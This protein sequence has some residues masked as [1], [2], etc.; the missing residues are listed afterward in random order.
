MPEGPDLLELLGLPPGGE[1]ARAGPYVRVPSPRR[2][3]SVRPRRVIALGLLA[4][5]LGVGAWQLSL[6]PSNER[7]WAPEQAVLPHV[8]IRGDTARVDRLRDFT[9][10]SDTTAVERYD[11]RTYDL[12]QIRRVWYVLSPF[13]PDWRGPAHSFFSFEFADSQFVSVSVE[14]RREADEAFSILGGALRQYE[15]MV[16][17]GSERDLI[18]LRAVTWDDPVYLYPGRATPEQARGLFVALL[19]R[20]ESLERRPEFYNTLS[21]NCTTNLLDAINGVR[22]TPIS[23]G[24]PVLFPGYSDRLAYDEGLLNT[25]LPLDSARAVFRINDRAAAAALAPDFS[26]RIRRSPETRDLTR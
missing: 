5:A 8:T 24:L 26:Q 14:A 18:G 20:A 15:L 3:M 22:E 7:A 1:V 4:A 9:H 17:V 11:S 13:N 23:Y 19:R 12:G 6:Q 25:D 10:T 2:A 16:V 21:N